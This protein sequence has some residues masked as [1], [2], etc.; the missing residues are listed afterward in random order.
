[1]LERVAPTTS[2]RGGTGRVGQQVDKVRT[3]SSR[4]RRKHR[5]TAALWSR[6]RTRRV[7]RHRY[8]SVMTFISPFSGEPLNRPTSEASL[9][10]LRVL[11]L[12]GVGPR[13]DRELLALS[14]AAKRSPFA[15]AEAMATVLG[16]SIRMAREV[17]PADFSE[18]AHSLAEHFAAA[19]GCDH[20]ANAAYVLVHMAEDMAC[21]PYPGDMGPVAA[22]DPR[23]VARATAFMAWTALGGYGAEVGC[24]LLDSYRELEG[25]LT[26]S[27][28]A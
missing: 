20:C 1:M 19:A 4:A 21:G 24:T 12:G 22:L 16:T 3:T 23:V 27:R 15:S 2:S 13:L 9:G 10:A 11:A 8:G 7:A 14:K 25:R 26:A 18:L 6:R 17:L 5:P 28:A